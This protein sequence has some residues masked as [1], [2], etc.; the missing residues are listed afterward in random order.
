MNSLENKAVINRDRLPVFEAL[1]A[2]RL[3]PTVTKE[4]GFQSYEML[5]G[6]GEYRK[7]QETAF[8]A[9]EM[10]NPT[11][12]YPKLDTQE[13]YLKTIP[14]Q[15]VI[16]QAEHMADPEA[17]KAVQSSAAYHQ[18]E[19]YW[20]I[21]AKKMDDLKDDPTS[22][23]FLE[24]A[25]QYQELNEVLYGA[26]RV[27]IVKQVYGEVIAQAGEKTLAPNVQ[28]IYD[29]LVNGAVVTIDGEDITIPA[30]DGKA[31]GRLP[32]INRES[33]ADLREVLHE[34]FP[35]VY[36]ITQNYWDEVILPRVE[37]TDDEPKFTVQD[38]ER[39][40]AKVREVMDPENT[41]RINIEVS[42]N[43]TALSWDTPTMAVQI[44]EKRLAIKEDDEVDA[45]AAEVMASK[46][47]HELATHGGRAING[48]KSELPVL[49]TGLYTDAEPGKNADYL[50]F[51]EGFAALAEI[52]SRNAEASKWT[53][54]YISRYL[55][56]TSLY[57]GADF[58][59]AFEVNWR[60]R[61]ILAAKDGVEM[62]DVAIAKEKKQAYLSTVRI[63]RGTPT[64]LVGG[65]V[66]TF[67]KDLAYLEGK[68]I[69]LEYLDSVKG[70]KKAIERLFTAKFDPTN[71]LQDA[72]V[73]AYG[74]KD[75]R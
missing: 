31:E 62:S 5:E 39:V 11:L 48:L 52:A 54:M 72:L 32:I 58:R 15:V 18:I 30:I 61:V 21:Q 1:I 41:S 10:R 56:A 60:A 6:S 34:K 28:A 57:E 68:I 51:E 43:K 19:M 55:A 12:D 66:L 42:P 20:L 8:F 69:A 37:G 25:R 29:E 75:N 49:G 4:M 3:R 67:N 16:D 33:L 23:E 63:T 17:A 40:F 14:L 7:K 9:G 53:P 46:I 2:E 59:Q 26:P 45:T 74:I 36:E 22:P 64:N 47:I 44:G 13:L 38:M 35:F 65:P 71:P 70:N 27:E 73:D 50:T 24:A